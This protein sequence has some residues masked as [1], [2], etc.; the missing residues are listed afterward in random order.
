MRRI[1]AIVIAVGTLA[2]C[3]G[4][5]VT[6]PSPVARVEPT[7]V[8]SPSP[9]PEP[10]PSPEATPEPPS[11]PDPKA[12]PTPTPA[13]VPTPEP[14]QSQSLTCTLVKGTRTPVDDGWYWTAG[15]KTKLEATV[16]GSWEVPGR[17]ADTGTWSG[18]SGKWK[19]AV[20]DRSC[21]GLTPTVKFSLSTGEKCTV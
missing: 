19:F 7:A 18:T 2:A 13:P 3:G 5:S 12:S 11:K 14:P 6:G 8:P 1:I 21:G 20:S 4:E 9:T 10:V 15:W 16:S 17:C